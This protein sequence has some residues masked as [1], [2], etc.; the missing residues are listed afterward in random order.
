MNGN[1]TY[2]KMLSA[3]SAS[4]RYIIYYNLTSIYEDID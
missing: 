2:I 1:D 4:N 3:L